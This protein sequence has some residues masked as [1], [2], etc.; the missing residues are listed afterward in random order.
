[1][2]LKKRY[3]RHRLNLKNITELYF[4]IPGLNL[5]LLCSWR[6]R[7]DVWFFRINLQLQSD[8]DESGAG[9]GQIRDKG[10]EDLDLIVQE[11]ILGEF[12][13]MKLQETESRDESEAQRSSSS[14][15]SCST[16][17]SYSNM[18]PRP[19]YPP[20]EPEPWKFVFTHTCHGSGDALQ[21]LSHFGTCH[22]LSHPLYLTY[23]QAAWNNRL[24]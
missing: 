22:C 14:W 18:D 24:K 20:S 4:E 5:F 19:P 23:C 6:C 21:K 15:F 13:V 16:I 1:M 8:S 9:H 12:R 17:S 10:S 3:E 2:F 11:V 7:L